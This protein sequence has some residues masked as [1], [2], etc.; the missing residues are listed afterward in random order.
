MLTLVVIER[1]V[2]IW[3]LY[4]LQAL[5]L[6]SSF[7]I[8]ECSVFALLIANYNYKHA[9]Y[10]SPVPKMLI[11]TNSN[12]DRIGAMWQAGN[13]AWMDDQS[14][15]TE[16]FPFKF[17]DSEYWTSE[18]CRYLPD[19]GYT[20]PDLALINDRQSLIA[21]VNALYDDTS[22]GARSRAFDIT[23]AEIPGLDVDDYVVTAKYET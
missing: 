2:V 4:Q 3:P 22:S 6:S 23:A 7:G 5:T 19:M 12:V 21:R 10:M 9:L 16:L 1:R 18:R 11:H 17:S 15:T 20:Y 14:N 13:N 8:G